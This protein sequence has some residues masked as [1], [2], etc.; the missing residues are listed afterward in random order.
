MLCMY[1]ASYISRFYD[2]YGER[3]WDRFGP[4][5]N[6]ANQVNF[7][8]HR[9]YLQRYIQ[10]GATVL[11]AGAGAGRFTI[12]LVRLGARVWVGDISPGQLALNAQ[13]V[14]EAGCAAGVVGRELLDIV[15]LA[16][17]P[18]AQF[19]AVVCYGGA[20]SYVFDQADRALGELL[21]VTRPGGYLLLSVMSLLGTTRA[22][23]PPILDIARDRGAAVVER[24]N[25]TGDLTP[26]L[27][28]HHAH[29]YRWSELAA[30]LGRHPC[31]ISA[32]SAANYLALSNE[33]A[34]QEIM[35]DPALWEAFLGWEV[36]FGKE[37]GA[38]DSGTHIL[39]VVQRTPD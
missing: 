4:A 12:E 32:A 36:D 7:H 19:D 26:D 18:A 5:A 21:R 1:D 27:S 23:L 34:V 31:T 10:P 20:L 24:V 13:R 37:P 8:V 9:W 2:D 30:L 3:E 29:M 28:P 11:E 17:F 15:D 6:P 39:A 16:R 35:D 33:A 25:A 22:V 14:E 38:L